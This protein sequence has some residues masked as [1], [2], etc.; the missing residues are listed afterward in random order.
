MAGLDASI[1]LHLENQCKA[2][3]PGVEIEVQ[4][5]ITKEEL[6]KLMKKV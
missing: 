3:P 4:K 1:I 2:L 5:R 6:K